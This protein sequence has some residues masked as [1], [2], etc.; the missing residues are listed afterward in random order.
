MIEL[1]Y[2]YFT[3]LFWARAPLRIRIQM[4][5]S[6]DHDPD[7]LNNTVDADSKHC[8]K[9]K[10]IS[11]LLARNPGPGSNFLQSLLGSSSS[12]LIISMISTDSLKGESTV[13]E[14]LEVKKKYELVV[15]L[16]QA[17]L[18]NSM[19]LLVDAPFSEAIAAYCVQV[20]IG[21]VM[22]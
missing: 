19:S 9:A 10:T 5:K 22:S 7:P 21:L 12:S 1:F 3:R 6:R 8:F 16:Q 20:T 17:C 2:F 15:L 13:W 14:Y 18:F 11:C 4:E